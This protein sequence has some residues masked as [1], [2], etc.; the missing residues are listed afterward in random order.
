MSNKIHIFT[1]IADKKR[2]IFLIIFLFSFLLIKSQ[3]NY[4]YNENFSSKTSLWSKYKGNKYFGTVKN[5]IYEIKS[6]EKDA[7]HLFLAQ[8]FINYKKDFSIETKIKQVSG[9]KNQGYGLTWGTRGWQNSHIFIISSSGY[10]SIGKYVSGK[11]VVTKNWTK[12]ANIKPINN[13][14]TLKIVKSGTNL[15]YYINNKPVYTQYNPYFNG[16]MHGFI[17]QTGIKCN[18]DYLKITNDV[19]EM[20]IADVDF[21]GVK[22]NIGTK[23][24]TSATEIA[25]IISPDGQTLF[26]ARAN[27]STNT[28]GY[29]DGGD[30]WFS[31]KLDNGKWEKAKNIGKPLNNTGVNVVVNIMPD[32]NTMFLEGLYN[33]NGSFKSDQ[34]ISVTY[35]TKNGWSVPRK[36]RVDN[37]YNKNMYETYFFTADQ[38]VLLLSVQRDDSYGDLDLYVSFRRSNGTY[39]K[40]KNMGAVINTFADEGTPFMAPDGKTLYF[41]TSGL[42]GY[43]S[44]DIYMS[45]RLDNSW[46]KWSKPKNLG[47]SINTGDWD[48]YLSLS[49]RGDTA[50]LVSSGNSYGNEDIFTI[51]LSSKLQPDEVVIISGRVLDKDSK[52]PIAAEIT[53]QN[54]NSGKEKGIARSNPKTGE[55]KIVLPYGYLYGFSAK[56]KDYIATNENIDLT[57]KANYKEI[58][59]NLFLSKMKVG[60]I[61]VLN[62]VFFEKG[63]AKLKST[64]FL[65]LNRIIKIMKDNPKMKIELRGHTDNRGNQQALLNL[66]QERVDIVK[67]Y[68]IKKGIAENRISTKAFGGSKPIN[69][70]NTETEHAKN[71]RVEFKII[72]F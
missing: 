35:R 2:Y 52:K 1:S 30:I 26:F 27:S 55:Y 67:D 23:I 40:P 10:F 5:G 65:E 58:K 42:Q 8:I 47:K 4:I 68:F 28:N 57:K 61:I 49:A 39:T 15:I 62:N 69:R 71:R 44:N 72:S 22:K 3:N 16:Q 53:Y 63:K 11:Y 43:G 31:K 54:L 29:S 48:T 13:Y 18:V 19:P 59:R 25:P 14:N 41:S 50:F 17:L 24:N 20:E 51:Q 66:S 9:K 46:L 21:K 56:A 34:G 45:K 36:V 33:S 64:S 38:K 70:N 6:S 60:E 37:F 32:G 7:I 12:S